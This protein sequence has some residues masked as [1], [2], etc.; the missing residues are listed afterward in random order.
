[1]FDL[2]LI[3][4]DSC[5]LCPG[6]CNKGKETECKYI[7]KPIHLHLREIQNIRLIFIPED[8]I[9]SSRIVVNLFRLL[10]T[11]YYQVNGTET[12]NIF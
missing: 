10:E 8:C 4:T 2:L 6:P 7:N 1:M 11:D 9:Y 12:K 3:K 5:G